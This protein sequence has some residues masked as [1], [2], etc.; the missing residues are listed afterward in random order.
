MQIRLFFSRD[1][2][3]PQN[4]LSISSHKVLTGDQGKAAS[5][6]ERLAEIGVENG[7]P[8][9]CGAGCCCAGWIGWAAGVVAG[10]VA[11]V[12]TGV[13]AAGLVFNCSIRLFELPVEGRTKK[14]EK[15]QSR[16]TT[17]AKIQVPFSNTSVVCLTPMNWLLSPPT[18][19]AKPPPFGF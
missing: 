11:G 6:Q 3:Q 4:K 16:A 12:V 1:Y 9:F 10:L 14:A 15:I 18:L 5:G 19:P 7:L 13:V 17:V 8:Y 2:F